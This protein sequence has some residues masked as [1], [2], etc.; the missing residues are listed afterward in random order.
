MHWLCRELTEDDKR[1]FQQ[2]M[3]LLEPAEKRR[4]DIIFEKSREREQKE[5]QHLK[6]RN[7]GYASSSIEVTKFSDW[8]TIS[9]PTD[10]HNPHTIRIFI[11]LTHRD[12][13][14]LNW[15]FFLLPTGHAFAWCN[16][17]QLNNPSISS[18]PSRSL[19][20]PESMIW[21]HIN[22]FQGEKISRLRLCT[23]AVRH[24]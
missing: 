17:T 2:L 13:S 19:T 12:Y 21:Y 3:A 5:S 6:E 10:L 15:D 16:H 1:F 14:W 23:V 9:R 24:L 4:H 22:N 8:I 20:A 7:Y 18:K 11:Q